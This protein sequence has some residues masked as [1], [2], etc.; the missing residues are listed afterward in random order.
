MTTDERFQRTKEAL[1][2]AF[3]EVARNVVLRAHVTGTKVVFWKDEQIVHVDPWETEVGRRM[4]AEQPA[5]RP[6]AKG[7]PPGMPPGTGVERPQDTND[8]A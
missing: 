8:K 1:D 4:L 7:M 3:E 6:W 2:A 5:G